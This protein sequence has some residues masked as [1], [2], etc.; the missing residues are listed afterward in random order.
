MS[1]FDAAWLALREPVDHASR[2]PDIAERVRRH[3]ASRASLTVVDLGC[4]TGSNLRALAA[5]LPPRQSWHLIDGDADL[6]LAA[7]HRLCDWADGSSRSA[8][9]VVL[10]KDG[11]RIDVR[12]DCADLTTCRLT[13]GDLG[14]DLVTAAALFDLVSR[15]WLERLVDALSERHVPIHAVLNYDGAAHW[16]PPG[17]LDERVVAAF[18]RHQGGDKGFGP[19]LGPDAGE[20]LARLC[21][22]RGY[23]TW[24]GDSPWRLL[25]ADAALIAALT[26][27]F[28]RA[29]GEIDPALREALVDWAEGHAK[30]H[31]VTIG[32]RDVFAHV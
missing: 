15:D 21:E 13:F 18:N 1:G 26:D 7:R 22:R 12:F 17:P 11:R 8:T 10:E 9:G 3:F 5:S 29:A 30:A 19:A 27:G 4:G 31:A 16:D 24:S 2:N 6:L 28:A 14:A 32:H 23:V 25:P 20:T